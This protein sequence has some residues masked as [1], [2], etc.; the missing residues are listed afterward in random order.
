MGIIAQRQNQPQRPVCS[1]FAQ[2]RTRHDFSVI[3]IHAPASG[4][5]QTKLAITKPGDEYEDEAD[6][7]ASQVIQLPQPQH[8]RACVCGGA[9]PRCQTEK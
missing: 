7:I 9:C 8:E 6:R 1:N 4:A 3:R 2:A 5:V